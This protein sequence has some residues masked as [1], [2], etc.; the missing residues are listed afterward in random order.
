MSAPLFYESPLPQPE[1]P[2]KDQRGGLKTLGV[3]MMVLASFSGCLAL[4]TPFTLLAPRP[5]GIPGASAR[6]LAAGLLLYMLAAFILMTI[7]VASLRVRR[8]A[9]P[10]VLVIAGTWAAMGFIGFVS[11]I[12]VAPDIDRVMAAAMS[13]TPPA[14]T[15]PATT[16]PA[17]TPPATAQPV[18][19]QPTTAPSATTLPAT[20][21]APPAAPPAATVAQFAHIAGVA[22]GV[23]MVV[24]MILLPAGL[25][26]F[27]RRES[28]RQT[29][30]YFDHK[31]SWTDY[32]PTPVLA[33][34][35]WLALGALFSMN[36]CLWGVVPAFGVLLHGPVAIAI[37]AGMAILQLVLAG[38]MLR[39]SPL[40]WWGTFAMVVL[41]GLSVTLT[42]A[43]IDPIDVYRLAGAP[44]EQI[45][46]IQKMGITTRG[47]LM[48]SPI[49]YGVAL[50]SYLLWVRKY[51]RPGA[52]WKPAAIPASSRETV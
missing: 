23:F 2:F 45:E 29:L 48:L 34:S 1:L 5:A 17:A 49:L 42:F 32:C 43:R 35:F 8:S 6:D 4:M 14:V 18:T 27:Y 15:Q 10:G 11:W 37:L 50:V 24:F 20:P 36:F 51:F 41:S 12:F 47:T 21:G 44:P 3:V 40:A 25:F 13:A 46:L 28:V 31:P 52:T 39:V 38:G 9:R 22:S 19:T 16:Q 7:G 33:V 26:W 30:E